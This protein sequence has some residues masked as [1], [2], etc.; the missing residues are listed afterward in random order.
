MIKWCRF[1]LHHM[2]QPGPAKQKACPEAG[3]GREMCGP[4]Q[5]DFEMTVKQGVEEQPLPTDCSLSV[6]A[7]G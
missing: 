2:S 4:T 1:W 3:R 7:P 5:R 6:R